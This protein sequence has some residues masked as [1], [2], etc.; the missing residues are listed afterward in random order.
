MVSGGSETGRAAKRIHSLLRHASGAPW[1]NQPTTNISNQDSRCDPPLRFF[2]PLSQT[3]ATLNRRLC[4]LFSSLGAFG[5]LF[6]NS[7][8]LFR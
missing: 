2:Q 3:R 6:L 5:G 8:H 1:R 4:P 7:L